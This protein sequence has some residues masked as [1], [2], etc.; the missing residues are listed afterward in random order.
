MVICFRI[1]FH[2]RGKELIQSVKNHDIRLHFTT[3]R[4]KNMMSLF[5]TKNRIK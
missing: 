3:I 5:T 2:R 1:K 4:F